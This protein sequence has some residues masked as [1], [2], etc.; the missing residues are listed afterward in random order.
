M[1]QDYEMISEGWKKEYH[2][3]HKLNSNQ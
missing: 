3:D 1:K 2:Y